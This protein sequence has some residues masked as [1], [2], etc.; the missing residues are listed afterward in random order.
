MNEYHARNRRELIVYDISGTTA[1]DMINGKEA[2]LFVN[3]LETV[4]KEMLRFQIDPFRR[5][6]G[7]NNYAEGLQ[8]LPSLEITNSRLKHAELLDQRVL[9]I[10]SLLLGLTI[11]APLEADI[12]VINNESVKSAAW[13][14]SNFVFKELIIGSDNSWKYSKWLQKELA[15]NGISSHSLLLQGSRRLIR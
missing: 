15:E 13:L 5:A 8:A 2:S 7:L 4:D 12:L 1:I 10:D 11:S 9:V 6:N 14:K 3:N